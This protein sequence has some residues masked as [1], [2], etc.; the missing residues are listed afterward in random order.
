MTSLDAAEIPR[1]VQTAPSR[2]FTAQDDGHVLA[3]AL[4][5]LGIESHE[6]WAWT[7][8]K[9]VV[10]ELCITLAAHRIV[11]IG[12]GR[13]PLFSR[14]EIANLGVDMTVNDISPAELAVLPA[15]YRTACFD[16][17]GDM[18]GIGDMRNSFDLAFS[19]MVFEHVADG[20][21]AWANLHQLLAPGGVA[22]AFIPTL[23]AMPFVLN[24]LLPD[25]LAAPIVR[26]F[27]PNRANDD[28][29]VFPARYSWCF[30]DDRR[31]RPML[32]AIGYR[33][34]AILPFYDHG[35]YRSFPVVRD[36]HR[37]FSDMAS[38]REWRLLA[39]FAYIAVR[40]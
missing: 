4:A 3:D 34:I 14:D 32:S 36:L 16:V 2:P 27:F 5:A 8:Y 11:E 39:S 21:R 23:Y 22:F 18:S 26:W 13:D 10:R 31:M 28:D 1:A 40:K 38:R 20:Q 30:A 19:R 35:Y 37:W 24:W 7:N 12:G 15:G 6:S 29:P 33:E 9:R 17:A 25:K